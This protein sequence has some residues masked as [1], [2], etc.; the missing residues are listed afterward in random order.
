[1][2][3]SR[4]RKEELVAKYTEQLENSQGTIFAHYNALNVPQM[5]TLRIDAREKEG[6]VF[7]IKNTL[8]QRVI[9]AGAYDVP[10]DLIGGRYV[11]G[12]LSSGCPTIGES[13]QKLR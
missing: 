5:E 10:D 3:I 4:A 8:F 11:G 12:F 13:F 2:A 1:M 6:R 7:V 9:D